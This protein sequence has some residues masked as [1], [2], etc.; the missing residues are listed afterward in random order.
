MTGLK[1]AGPVYVGGSY[2]EVPV[3]G[4][5]VAMLG[6]STPCRPYTVTA[7]AWPRQHKTAKRKP[8]GIISESV[9]MDSVR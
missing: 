4:S 2:T 9:M 1:A 6:A 7:R 3:V 8:C 5:L